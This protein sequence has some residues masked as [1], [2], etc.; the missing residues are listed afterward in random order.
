M[1]GKKFVTLHESYMRR[2]E[3]GGFLVG[4]V[5]KFNDDYKSTE[6]YK[7]FGANTKDLLDQ[8]IDSGLHIRV[9]GI[10]DTEPSRFPANAE[11]SSLGVVL[12]IALDQGGGRTTHHV[13]V[14]G[15]LGQAIQYAPNL[16]PIPDAMRRK[17]K[18]IIK[19]EE[20]EEDPNNIQNRTARGTTGT[21]DHVGT[22]LSPTERSLP[23]QNTKIPSDPA[24]PSPDAATYTFQYLSDLKKGSSMY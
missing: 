5:F 3:R 4:D 14:P 18:V 23:K 2:Y 11:T 13:T 22:P 12:N 10:K 6:C 8:M 17:D 16:L 20:A 15:E 19:P 24:T 1:A 21:E 7:S 9:T